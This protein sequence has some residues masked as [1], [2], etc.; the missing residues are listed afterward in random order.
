MAN[1]AELRQF[2]NN[3]FSDDELNAL[4]FD[5]FPE[6]LNNFAAGMTK[7]QKVI[8]LLSYCERRGLMENLL[9]AL[10]ILRSEPYQKLIDS[11]P[12]IK[13]KERVEQR[14][15]NRIF[16]SH[17]NQDAGFAQAL[18]DD[19]SRHDYDVWIAPSS[20]EPGEKW[21]DAIERGLETS[22]I[23]LLVMTPNAAN[24]SWVKDESSYAIDLENKGEIRLITLDVADG[25]LPPMWRV[26]QHISFRQDYDEGLKQLLAALKAKKQI[27]LEIPNQDS[28]PPPSSRTPK[29]T[30]ALGGFVIVLLFVALIYALLDPLGDKD[31]AQLQITPTAIEQAVSV[32]TRIVTETAAPARTLVPTVPLSPTPQP[33][34]NPSHTPAPP[35]T[36]APPPVINPPTVIVQVFMPT[37][38]PPPIAPTPLP[39]AT[40]TITPIPDT[41]TPTVT[42]TPTAT[43]TTALSEA[44]PEGIRTSQ[45]EVYDEIKDDA[46]AISV[47]VP[48][49]WTINRF[50]HN[51]EENGTIM[52][53]QLL[54]SS[55][56]RII[57]EI[58]PFMAIRASRLL[59]E[60][61]LEDL[62]SEYDY[63]ESCTYVGRF[64][65]DDGYYFGY[66]DEFSNCGVEGSSLFVVAAK[67]GDGSY[68]VIVIVH[69]LTEG[70]L[71]ARD[72]IWNTF[73]ITGSRLPG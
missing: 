12:T 25:K 22:G 48:R 2:I 66:F 52:G 33:T 59:G 63:S 39:T 72:K 45:Y 21:V 69:T 23:F 58:Y 50:G 36:S 37:S 51:W 27:P 44:S 62:L 70:D 20:I 53:S 54:A 18:A 61:T 40:P 31:E 57:G 64:P 65:Y 19:L 67:P 43:P 41:P 9:A 6:V 73:F 11:L 68:A 34:I 10:A 60:R 47:M 15:P 4:C 30:F 24:S 7:S 13:P 16:L 28:T 26:R 1:K 49:E 3:Y 46:E 42:V 14:Y 8:D 29:W 5:Y 71:I 32:V 35:P 56:I 17:A 55:G 38:P